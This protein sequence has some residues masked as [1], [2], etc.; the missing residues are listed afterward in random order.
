MN[1]DG[2]KVRTKRSEKNIEINLTENKRKY[3]LIT[4]F[5]TFRNLN[6]RI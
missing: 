6:H 3:N 1:C 5:L 2:D 4:N